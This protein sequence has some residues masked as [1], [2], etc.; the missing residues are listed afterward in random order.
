M[1]VSPSPEQQLAVLVHG[2]HSV[3]HVELPHEAEPEQQSLPVALIWQPLG[4]VCVPV[5]T[6]L[7]QV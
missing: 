6:K 4:Q 5:V 2:C 7:V 3:L 1:Q